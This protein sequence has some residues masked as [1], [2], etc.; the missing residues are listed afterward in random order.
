MQ[1]KYENGKKILY[2]PTCGKVIPDKEDRVLPGHYIYEF[3]NDQD[4][5]NY[6]RYP[7]F[8][9]GKHPKGHCLPCCFDK[10]NTSTRLKSKT[11]CESSTSGNESSKTNTKDEDYIIAPDKFPLDKGRWG[12]L[13][14]SIQNLLHYQGD[15]C[16]I[17]KTNTN[18]RDN[19][20]CLLRH[21]IESNKNQSFLACLA[22]VLNYGKDT[23]LTVKQLKEKIV[24]AINIDNFIV[25][26][27]GNL[28][29]NFYDGNLNV[30]IEKYQTSK[31]YKKINM[32]NEF[33]LF[34]LK[35]VINA[36]DNFVMYLKDDSVVI[37]HTYLW[38]VISMPNENIYP[39]GINI[40]IL[41]LPNDDIT[42]NV[43]LICPTNHHAK[44]LYQ[45]KKPS[46]LLLKEDGYYEPIYTVLNNKSSRQVTKYIKENDKLLSK[47]LKA[48]INDTVKPI[49][50][51]IC[52]PQES[53]IKVVDALQPMKLHFLL[54]S[55][56]SLSYQPDKLVL[57]FRNK[58][59]AVICKH[60]DATGYVPCLP[61]GIP[62][63][64][65]LD[66]ILM[67]QVV[68]NTYDKTFKFLNDLS[69][70][71]DKL[72]L[73]R[74]PC[75]P[76]FKMV[77]DEMVIGI[78]TETNQL[79]QIS[80]PITESEIRSTSQLPS[81]KNT[82]F[83]TKTHDDSLLSDITLMTSQ[84]KDVE[85]VEFV[86]QIRLETGFYNVF[87]N[88]LK[89]L[90]QTYEND[91]QK[92][93]LEE[94]VN[95]RIIPYNYKLEEVSSILREL[96][97]EHV[98]FTGDDKYHNVIK[99]ASTCMGKTESSCKEQT[100]LCLY[101]SDNKC[102]L[103]LP[104]KNIVTKKDNSV[105]YIEKMADE[106]I[107]YGRIN[108]YIF[109][110]NSYLSFEDAGYNL[111]EN[112]LLIIQ[113]L[114]TPAY[115][116]NLVAVDE[117][118]YVKTKSYDETNYN[119]DKTINRELS[120]V[121]LKK[122][123]SACKSEI[124]TLGSGL[125]Y[126]CLPPKYRQSQKVYSHNTSY[127]T[128][129]LII[130]L[131]EERDGKTYTITDIKHG[132][133]EE[134]KKHIEIHFDKVIDILIMEGK[135]DYGNQTKSGKMQFT[136]F[137]YA[138]EYYLTPLDIW[139]LSIH[140]QLP[141]I[142]L[143]TKPFVLTKYAKRTFICFGGRT[144]QYNYIILPEYKKQ[145]IPSYGI[146]VDDENNTRFPFNITATKNC[147]EDFSLS[148][149]DKINIEDFLSDY[150]KTSKLIQVPKMNSII[151]ED[152]DEEIITDGSVI[153][154]VVDIGYNSL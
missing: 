73:K 7:N 16:Q 59:I 74:I 39:S 50:D 128:F 51:N 121:V 114:L 89:S 64:G 81:F 142:L 127:C 36:Y 40:L 153:E 13:P 55:L 24:N 111:N 5:S 69:K 45:S 144:D 97:K 76:M 100:N 22:D 19:H 110:S 46:I 77:E 43:R 123:N 34:Y 30:A 58:I 92:Q 93:R 122:S 47:T 129:Q 131:I 38:D 6:K 54:S 91:H 32:S 60:G 145:Q 133:F 125:I 66:V 135:T 132:L 102:Q 149:D 8:A 57:N 99:N 37:D 90:I 1:T 68:W 154:E 2:H 138:D 31:L 95:N 88:T 148:I 86:K 3:Y 18:L 53:T 96:G 67:T 14:I 70:K 79:I 134:Y 26:H 56:S 84:D 9:T 23:D 62:E 116:D 52:R 83:L 107:R 108:A 82:D 113:S 80:P 119:K 78:L 11:H 109:N 72:E 48:F 139:V 106:I 150:K 44:E 12:Y 41:E 98:K 117:I 15:R 25:Y 112:E 147:G 35:K 152:S 61:S 103:I 137:L 10:W 118:H 49:Y 4:K 115:F 75:K 124:I 146:I 105:I 87:R 130:D 33:E 140:F 71:G 143:S 94:V 29:N 120:K 17:S 27:N 104:K 28:V 21:G 42:S 126:K 136:T 63:R 141:I 101:S 151:I 20:P 65:E 85:R